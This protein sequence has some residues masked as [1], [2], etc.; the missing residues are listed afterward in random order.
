MRRALRA[1]AAEFKKM[2]LAA[3]DADVIGELVL[4]ARISRTRGPD[5]TG[6]L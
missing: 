4:L 2:A 3:R 6:R 5:G 1:K